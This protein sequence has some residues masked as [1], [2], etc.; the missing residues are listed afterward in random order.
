M[1]GE[2]KYT[3]RCAVEM[4]KYVVL[5]TD[6]PLSAARAQVHYLPFD[7]LAAALVNCS[8]ANRYTASLLRLTVCR[9]TCHSQLS[10]GSLLIAATS[11]VQLVFVYTIA[12]VVIV[13]VCAGG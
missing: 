1:Q 11:A 10:Y 3:S 2:V 9:A 12:L 5:V 4:Q 8:S 6:V 7:I 13:R